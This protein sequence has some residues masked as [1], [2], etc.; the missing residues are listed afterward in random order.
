[1]KLIMIIVNVLLIGT[2]LSIPRQDF[3]PDG[4]IKKNISSL[5]THPIT[6]L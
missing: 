3:C 2:Q 1:M 5:I 4:K 6:N